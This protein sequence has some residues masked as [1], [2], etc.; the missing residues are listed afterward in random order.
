MD[1]SA[2]CSQ[3]LANVYN[4]IQEEV[5]ITKEITSNKIKGGQQLRG[6]NKKGRKY[7]RQRVNET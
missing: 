4:E 1:K 5:I 7:F 2:Q 3:K 6:Y